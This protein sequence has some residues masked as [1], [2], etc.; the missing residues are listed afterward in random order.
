VIA[1]SSVPIAIVANGLRIAGTGIA[2]QYVGPGAA[3]GF[4]HTFSG[5]TVFMTSFVMLVAFGNALKM[6]PALSVSRPER[7]V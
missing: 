3:S 2:A 4:F 7:S 5:W 1:L 6:L